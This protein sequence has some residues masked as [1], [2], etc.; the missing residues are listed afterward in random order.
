[1]LA[2]WYFSKSNLN[3]WKFSVH[4]LLKP[5]LGNFEHYF[6]CMWDECN[7]A[8]VWTFFGI[9]FLCDWN[10]N[11]PFPVPWPLLSFPNLLAYW[12]HTFTAS[13]FR[14]WNNSDGI[15]SPPLALFFV[16]FPKACLT[17]AARCLALGEWPHHRGYVCHQDLFCIVLCSLATLS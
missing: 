16:M 3:I 7:C 2:I 1:M 9:A 12:A 4:I 6:S 15:P 8:V 5:G 11:W 17:Y 13:S 14:I 10:E